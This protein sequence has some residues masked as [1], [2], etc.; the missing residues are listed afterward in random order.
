MAVQFKNTSLQCRVKSILT[1]LIILIGMETVSAQKGTIRGFVYD[2]ENGEPVLFT[3][4]YLR[5][6]NY[7]GTTDVNGYYS[8]NSIAPGNY[9]LMVTSI[10]YDS[11]LLNV[12]VKDGDLL[13]KQLYIKKGVIRLKTVE[14]SAE[15]EA[16]RTEVRTSVN[17]VTPRDIQ[18]IP[19]VG[20]EPDFAQYLQVLPGVV[21]SGDQG[22][23][24]YIRG[25][26]PVMNKVLLDG[27][28]IYNPFHSIGLFSVFDAD[29]IKNAD[30]YTGGFNAEYGGRIASVMDIT[31]RDGNKKRIA[32]K[33]SANTFSSK[34]L[35][36]GP[37]VKS[38]EGGSGSSFIF[39]AKN[40]Y[41]NKTSPTIYKYIDEKGLPY[42]FTDIYSKISFYGGNG[43][44]LSLFGFSFQ[45]KAN[46]QFVTNN[47]WKSAGGGFNFVLVP[48]NSANL[49]D[50][51]FA[52]S[53][54]RITQQEA[55]DNPRFSLVNGFNLD[56]NFT[57]Y[58]KK[59]EV[60]YGFQIL[61]FKTEYEKYNIL[62]VKSGQKE[63]TT[64]FGSFVK[65][66][67]VKNKIVLE[68]GLRMHFYSSLSEISFEPRLGFKYNINDK[69][70]F[71]L[72]G[73][74][75]SQN[76][77]STVS[78]RDVVNIFY[79]FL[80]GPESLPAKFDGKNVTSHLQKAKDAI[81]GMEIDLHRNLNLNVEVYYKKFVQ[82]TNVNRDKVFPD[83]G[84]YEDKPDNLKKDY[85]VE[86]GNAYGGDIVLKYDYKRLYIWLVYS[87]GYVDRY[88]GNITYMP[89]FDRRHNANVVTSYTFGKKL[90]WVFNARWNIGSGFP[91]TKTAG[92]YEYLSFNDG[93]Y[94][95][96]NNTN[97]DLGII[98]GKLNDGRL[99]PYHRLDFS[100]KKSFATGKNSVFEITASVINVYNR[101]NI[102]YFD[103]VRYKRID[104]LPILPAIGA[105]LTF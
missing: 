32:G 8:I 99:P 64:E 89:H 43:S 57:N 74:F 12:E 19:A 71:K 35:V 10:G 80:S 33:V 79:G 14:I 11:L 6:T 77:L 104:Q 100:L 9:L 39:T 18:M 48:G 98:Y 17:K 59:N 76:L 96:L 15:K 55:E 78:D 5:G 81:A 7:S 34:I 56:M 61:G 67:W 37:L 29:I 70:R 73:G 4:V 38:K 23:Q 88:N 27:M 87:L 46:Y 65:Y 51:N 45:D 62:N 52:Y 103:R 86:S 58:N 63:Y 22:G 1:L 30:V 83:N 75:Y 20:G 42:S 90:N 92:F 82:L 31:T 21:S 94:T 84:D 72:A 49:I 102:F 40:S 3:N 28:V 66:R 44:K 97:G 85:I 36:E 24:L 47:E 69:I 53:K 68:P 2:K 95:N 26:T 93:L 105:T 16:A 91:F 50:G 101:Q 41:L 13:S 54:Y 60:R 25:G